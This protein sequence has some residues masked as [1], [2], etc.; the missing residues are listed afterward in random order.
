MARRKRSEAAGAVR[1]SAEELVTVPVAELV[2]YEHNA[3]THS[4][5]QVERLRRSLREFGFMA[6]ILIDEERRVIAGHGRLLAAQAEGMESVP[7][8]RVGSLTEAQRRAY[9]LADNRLAEDAGWDEEALRFELD[10]I[11]ALDFDVSFTGFDVE[12]GKPIHVREHDREKAGRKKETPEHFWGDDGGEPETDE[13]Y[14]AFV[15]KFRR[16]LTTDDCYTPENIYQAIR[17]WAVEHYGL[18]DAPILRPFY[19]GGD[20]EHENYPEGCVVIDNPPFSILSQICR[21]YQERDIRYF[22]FAP[23]LTLFSIA[24][25]ECNYVVSSTTIIYDNGALVRTGF[26]TNLGAY[27]IEACPD[28]YQIVD[29]INAENIAE[30]SEELP[31]Y[32]YPDCVISAA[33]IAKTAKWEALQIL[34]EDAVFVRALDE[35]RECGKAIYGGG[36]LLS[37]KAAAEK[38]AAEKA[39]AEKAAAEKKTEHVWKLSKREREIVERLGKH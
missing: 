26:V 11:A 22:L 28:L 35:Q 9:I 31:G 32:T 2:P 3:R 19:P 23:A 29:K 15:D 20:Y 6:P 8:V 33:P 21:F 7:C 37:E 12:P 25:G 10:E 18:G 16:K 5:E 4:D 30:T 24:A 36:F 14:D 17:D 1:I 39:A 38:A 27:K 34:P 13:E